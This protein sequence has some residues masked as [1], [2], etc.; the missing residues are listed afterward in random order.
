MKFYVIE[1]EV[2][3]GF[4]KNSEADRSV[5]P[6]IIYLVKSTWDCW[7]IPCR[8]QRKASACPVVDYS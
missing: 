3:G 4:G 1:P 8:I 7:Q 6:P 5:H 2:A